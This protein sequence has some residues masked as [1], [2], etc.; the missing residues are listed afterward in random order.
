MRSGRFDVHFS[1]PR[2]SRQNDL[3]ANRIGHD[4]ASVIQVTVINGSP[5]HRFTFGH[6]LFTSPCGVKRFVMYALR[7]AE[8]PV[9]HPFRI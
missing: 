7:Q 8:V 4:D 2:G 6:L 9:P 5:T 3:G 1:A